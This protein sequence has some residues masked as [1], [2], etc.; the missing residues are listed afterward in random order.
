[1]KTVTPHTG[2][3]GSSHSRILLEF[4]LLLALLLILLFVS[5]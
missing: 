4:L 3:T 1:M 5:G 2:E